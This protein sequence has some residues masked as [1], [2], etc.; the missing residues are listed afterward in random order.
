MRGGRGRRSQL[1]GLDFCGSGAVPALRQVFDPLSEEQIDAVRAHRL[2]DIAFA[3]R[4]TKRD[5]RG[6]ALA[7]L[8]AIFT[9]Q[10]ASVD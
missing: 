6:G 8:K 10:A 1:D 3:V 2:H 4:R 9:P 5:F 7:F